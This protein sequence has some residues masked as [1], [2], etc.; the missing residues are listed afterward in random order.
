M[1]QLHQILFLLGGLNLM[2]VDGVNRTLQALLRYVVDSLNAL[3]S[4]GLRLPSMGNASGLQP[5]K[6]FF[7]C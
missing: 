3:S 7:V 4:D 2:K 1:N 6:P 5:L